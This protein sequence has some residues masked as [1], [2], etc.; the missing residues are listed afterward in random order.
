MPIVKLIIDNKDFEVECGDGEENLLH[1]AEKKINSKI[2]ILPELKLLPESKKFLML[3]LILA[4]DKIGE[5]E[6]NNK[7][8]DKYKDLDVELSKLEILI[9]K[10]SKP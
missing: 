4:G 3:S 8:L 7:F 6:K 5:D 2:E 9:K 10:I 1:E